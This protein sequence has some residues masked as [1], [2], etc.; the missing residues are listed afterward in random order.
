MHERRMRRALSTVLLSG[1]LIVAACG[2]GAPPG[3]PERARS[4]R[5]GVSVGE[6]TSS[7]PQGGVGQLAQNLTIEGIANFGDDGRARPWLAD[8]WSLEPSG[9]LLTVRLRNNVLFQD[10]THLTSGDVASILAATLPKTMGPA[11][12]DVDSISSAGA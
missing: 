7:D 9:R 5:V 11:Y 12:T 1:G 6:L 10:G 2:R 4:I 3:N 8:S